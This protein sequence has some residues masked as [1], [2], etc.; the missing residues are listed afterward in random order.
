VLSP[1]GP[2]W[3]WCLFNF[4]KRRLQGDLIASLQYLRGL[5]KQEGNQLLTWPDSIRTMGNGFKL[6]EGRFML[7]G[8]SLLR[9]Q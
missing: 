1:S 6:K 4:E 2:S 8:N 3:D 7:G 9:G 5:Y